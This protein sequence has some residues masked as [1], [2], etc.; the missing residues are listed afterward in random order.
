MCALRASIHSTGG[1]LIV[2]YGSLLNGD[3]QVKRVPAVDGV[4]QHL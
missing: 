1:R 3:I 2:H 4:K